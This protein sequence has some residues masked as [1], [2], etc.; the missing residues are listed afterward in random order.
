M[1]L[2]TKACG[3]LQAGGERCKVSGE[4]QLYALQRAVS[5]PAAL[6]PLSAA[7][8]AAVETHRGCVVPVTPHVRFALS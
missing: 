1:R 4:H 6:V 3:L 7:A 2:Q 5:L 8:A